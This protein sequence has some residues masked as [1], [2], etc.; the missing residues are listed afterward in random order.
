MIQ[1]AGGSPGG[2]PSRSMSDGEGGGDVLFTRKKKQE[3][4]DTAMAVGGEKEEVDIPRLLESRFLRVGNL[5][6]VVNENH[7]REI[8]SCYGEVA[9]VEL[10]VDRTVNQP[11]GFAFV[12]LRETGT[13][14]EAQTRMDG[15]NIDGNEVT[16]T[17]VDNLPPVRR[18]SQGGPPGDERGGRGGEAVHGREGPRQTSRYDAYRKLDDG[19]G[20]FGGGGRRG[21]GDGGNG[22]GFDAGRN[23]RYDRSRGGGRGGGG[24][25][26]GGR[27]R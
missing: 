19:G 12:E 22:G 13:A 21:F 27:G 10:A 2:T 18:S 14:G 26:G 6:R 5:T 1:M 8:F 20:H 16:V 11:T 17:F 7:L 3:E 24:R 23:N 4:E 9:R 15:G 25:G